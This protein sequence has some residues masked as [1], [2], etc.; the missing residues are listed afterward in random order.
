MFWISLRENWPMYAVYSVYLWGNG[1]WEAILVTH[2]LVLFFLRFYLLIHERHRERERQKQEKQAPCKDPNMGLLSGSHPE[3]KADTQPLSDPGVPFQSF[4][5]YAQK[6]GVGSSSIYIFNFFEE[7]Q[8]YFPYQL[9]LFTI[10]PQCT[11]FPIS[12]HPYMH[13]L[14]SSFCFR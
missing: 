10:L 11:K 1:K 6:W 3:P 5:I 8:Y 9:H 7:L 2:S 13:T 4:W 12:L 14:F